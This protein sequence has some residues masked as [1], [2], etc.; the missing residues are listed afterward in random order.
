M[1]PC[2]KWW[3]HILSLILL[4]IAGIAF[5]IYW[6]RRE[7]AEEL[8]QVLAEIDQ[9]DD[10]WRLKQIEAK[11]RVIPDQDNGTFIVMKAYRSLPKG[12]E[13]TIAA[14]L[15]NE[16]RDLEL[17]PPPVALPSQCAKNLN[18]CLIAVQQAVIEARELNETPRGRFAVEYTP[19]FISSLVVEQQNGRA[20]AQLLYLDAFALLHSSEPTK[21][22][23]SVQA[24]F[25]AGRTMADEPFIISQLVRM[26]Y[27]VM[28]VQCIERTLGQTSVNEA[29]LSSLQ[30][31]AS[32]EAREDLFSIAIRG[33]RA[34]MNECLSNIAH[35]D[36]PIAVTVERIAT[37]LQQ[38]R[39]N[40]FDRFNDVF[41]MKMV[42]RSH[43]WL[44]RH[45][46]Q[47]IE[48]SSKKGSAKYDRLQQWVEIDK[49]M[50]IQAVQ[51]RDLMLAALLAP[52]ARKIAERERHADTLLHCTIAGLAA[53]RFR[54]KHQRW[55]E[56]LDELIQAKLLAEAPEDLYDGKPIRL[57][58]TADGIVFYSVGKD[59]NYQGDA[60][61]RLEEFNPN[62]VRVEF[63]LWDPA[64]RRQPPL[65][66]RKPPEDE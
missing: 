40:W 59:G 62:Q 36:K 11:R 65:P 31:I 5:N 21:T 49:H 52:S 39:E 33:E 58:R 27:Q 42:Y 9:A 30:R 43:A 6:Q 64:K 57:R 48:D 28:G 16:L 14:K 66:P 32:E 47:L 56:S 8:R 7:A 54:L 19:D 37:M 61:D 17:A 22:L 12:W 10:G 3:F 46:T 23:Q 18:E 34:G 35:G 63:R 45:Y 41:A 29:V 51:N 60:L 1:I 24:L 25:H 2:R 44:M 4:A 26:N 53:E 20:V 15:L 50:K 55:P 13:S 38:H